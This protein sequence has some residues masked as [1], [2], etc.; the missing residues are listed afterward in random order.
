MDA[1]IAVPAAC[2]A[3]TLFV[4]YLMGR[5]GIKVG[6]EEMVLCFLCG[7]A[8]AAALVVAQRLLG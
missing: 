3:I 8:G 7:A 1:S 6:E 5:S 2:G 4:G